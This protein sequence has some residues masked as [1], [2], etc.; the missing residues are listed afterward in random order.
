MVHLQLDMILK[1]DLVQSSQFINK[2]TETQ[3]GELICPP[4]HNH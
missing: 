1:F 2:E 3:E 4:F